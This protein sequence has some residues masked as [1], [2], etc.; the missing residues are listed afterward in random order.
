MQPPPGVILASVLRI[1]PPGMPHVVDLSPLMVRIS[2]VRITMATQQ[3]YSDI[4]KYK[5]S[6]ERKYRDGLSDNQ[7]RN[8]RDKSSRYVVSST[9]DQ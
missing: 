7:K 1:F 9:Y 6:I 3:E 8:I 2:V 5:T 4:M